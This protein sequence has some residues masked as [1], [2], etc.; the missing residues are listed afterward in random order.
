MI[1]SFNQV[2]SEAL[3]GKRIKVWEVTERSGSTYLTLSYFPDSYNQYKEHEATIIEV[4]RFIKS[5]SY[6]MLYV[7]INNHKQSIRWD[8]SYESIEFI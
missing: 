3:L 5:K 1:Q 2:L 7:L 8:L 6:I 4:G